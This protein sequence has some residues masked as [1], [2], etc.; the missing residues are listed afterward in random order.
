EGIEVEF[1]N[2]VSLQEAL[3]STTVDFTAWGTPSYIIA[4]TKGM[5]VKWIAG[6]HQGGH[7]VITHK[8]SG[9]STFEDLLG[10]RIAVF[11]TSA[12]PTDISLKLTLLEKG[13]DF[14][15]DVQLVPMDA[16]VIAMSVRQRA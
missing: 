4:I 9:I 13:Y 2:V 15:K 12:G 16:A 6:L 1:I 10:K 7:A 8:E 11:P 5:P 3:M 14:N